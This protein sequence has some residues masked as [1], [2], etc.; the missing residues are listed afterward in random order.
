[1]EK[2]LPDVHKPQICIDITITATLRPAIVRRSL[3]SLK[4]LLLDEIADAFEYRAIVNID[5]IGEPGV[6]Q[7][8]VEDIYRRFFTECQVFTPPTPSFPL[9]VKRV[10]EHAESPIVFH[11][12]D[13]KML[14]RPV[15]L[16]RVVAAFDSIGPLAAVSLR[17][18]DTQAF[19]DLEYRLESYSGIY[20][21]PFFQRAVALLPSF[22]RGV[23]VREMASYMREGASPE[24]TIRA[25][26]KQLGATLAR[27]VRTTSEKYQY[28]FVGLKGDGQDPYFEN[29]GRVWRA[30]HR[31]TKGAG[32]ITGTW[33]RPEG[34][35]ERKNYKALLKEVRFSWLDRLKNF[36]S[37]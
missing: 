24:K 6:T 28:G 26:E 36:F 37:R 30:Q 12:E 18:L 14:T 16:E 15:P 23:Y 2:K 20:I 17:A 10:W 21:T 25:H 8:D 1:M 35:V 7:A 34:R 9:A 29:I 4:R 32:G 31:F 5:P 33:V 3:D 13:S 27:S 11:C 22:F 19:P